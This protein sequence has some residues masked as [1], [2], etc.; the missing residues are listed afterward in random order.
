MVL[1]NFVKH[2]KKVEQQCIVLKTDNFDFI[3]EATNWCLDNVGLC[4]E[5]PFYGK[6]RIWSLFAKHRWARKIDSVNHNEFEASF[7]FQNKQ[8]QMQFALIFYKV[9]F[10]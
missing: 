9:D 1:Y 6:T 4:E 10:K 2:L 3:I 8:D 5:H 7:W